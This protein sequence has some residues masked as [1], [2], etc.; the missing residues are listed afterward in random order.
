MQDLKK[1]KKELKN[2]TMNTQP[3]LL[4]HFP[5]YRESDAHCDEPDQAPIQE[6]SVK[7]REGWDCISRQSSDLLLDSV[8]PRLVLSGHTHHGCNTSHG[9]T[10]EISVS[11]F[12][13]RN[14]KK[15]AFLLAY[16]SQESYAIA[17]CYMPEENSVYCSYVFFIS[18]ILFS[19]CKK[20]P[21]AVLTYPSTGLPQYW[22]TRLNYTLF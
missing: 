21:T 10:V 14:K 12:S 15:P 18:L 9:G 1:L 11:S 19:L 5:L 4:S 13:W 16:F 22:P 20:Y 6:K 8:E 17:K 7:F 2:R 3:V